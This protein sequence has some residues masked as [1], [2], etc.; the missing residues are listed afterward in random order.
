MRCILGRRLRDRMSVKAED[1]QLETETSTNLGPRQVGHG[2]LE[3]QA[4]AVE[5]R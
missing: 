1:Q 4:R 3:S 5:R 2:L